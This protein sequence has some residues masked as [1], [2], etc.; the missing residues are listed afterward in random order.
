MRTTVPGTLHWLDSEDGTLAFELMKS[1]RWVNA[2]NQ[3]VKEELVSW[4]EARQ[5][6][7]KALDLLN[8]TWEGVQNALKHG[9]GDEDRASVRCRCL[10]P[11]TLEVTIAQENDWPGWKTA[12]APSRCLD[13]D[14]IDDGYGT[15]VILKLSSEVHFLHEHKSLR[16]RFFCAQQDEVE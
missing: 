8:A 10:T 12:L 1:G 9:I 3:Y 15:Y 13:P 11:V 16:M 2:F 4:A 6:Q 7:R 5:C 14:R